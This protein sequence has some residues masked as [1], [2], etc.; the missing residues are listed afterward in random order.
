MLILTM[1][2]NVF[3]FLHRES[4]SDVINLR[5]EFKINDAYYPNLKTV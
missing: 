3:G 4:K 1:T 5:S 2:P